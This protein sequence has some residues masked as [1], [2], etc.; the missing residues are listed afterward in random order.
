MPARSVRWRN[1]RERGRADAADRTPA[2]VPELLQDVA[3]AAVLGPHLPPDDGAERRGA[4]PGRAAGRRPAA[5]SSRAAGGDEAALPARG[6]GLVLVEVLDQHVDVRRRVGAVR[7]LG[8]IAR[9]QRRRDAEVAVRRVGLVAVLGQPDPLPPERPADLADEPVDR[10]HRDR[11]AVAAAA[12]RRRLEPAERIRVV[13]VRVEPGTRRVHAADEGDRRDPAGRAAR[14]GDAAA[15]L[16]ARRRA[17][18]RGVRGVEQRLRVDARRGRAQPAP[19]VRLVPDQPV[20]D[21]RIPVGGAAR[22]AC[23]P[24]LRARRPVRASGRRSPSA[25]CPRSSPPAPS[26]AR[27]GPAGSRPT[28]P[29]RSAPLRASIS[30]QFERVADELDAHRVERVEALVERARA[31]GDPG[32][33]LEP[34]ADVRRRV[35]RRRRAP[36]RR[37]RRRRAR[38]SISCEPT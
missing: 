30:F 4:R 24:P 7:R 28:G 23:E 16:R 29:S 17:V 1:P 33:V 15:D 21:E 37:R 11:L 26:R 34:V 38:A 10:R 35:G 31:V 36:G 18:D 3:L 9:L 8:E 22:E 25:A 20:L 13:R 32:I 6:V 2:A 5:R 27:G 12:R 19:L 14:R